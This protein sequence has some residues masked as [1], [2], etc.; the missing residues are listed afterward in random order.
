[1]LISVQK[2]VFILK[3]LNELNAKAT[4]GQYTVTV[5]IIVHLPKS[6]KLYNGQYQAALSC[7]SP[8][9]FLEHILGTVIIR[10]VHMHS[11]ARQCGHW[12]VSGE[13]SHYLREN[14]LANFFLRV[15][16]H[17]IICRPQI[18]LDAEIEPRNTRLDLVHNVR[19]AWHL[20]RW[21][22]CFL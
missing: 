3:V 5:H 7:N 9:R 6:T 1:V 4:M 21:T 13:K 15:I 12:T 18:P 16:Q 8:F 17:C 2:V 22:V 11:T 20:Y 14:W 10:A 19:I